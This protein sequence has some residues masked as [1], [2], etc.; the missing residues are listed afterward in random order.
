M[1]TGSSS[2]RFSVNK[3][4]PHCDLAAAF[5]AGPLA[6]C[7]IVWL[8]GDTEFTLLHPR[9]ILRAEHLVPVHARG[10]HQRPEWRRELGRPPVDDHDG[11][12][13]GDPEHR[14]RPTDR[15]QVPVDTPISVS[16]STSMA[17]AATEDAIQL[18]PPVPGTRVVRNRIDTSRFV[19]LPGAT[20]ESGVTYRLSIAATAAT[21]NQQPLV[22]AS[23]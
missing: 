1:D 15:D 18:S 2:G 22:P 13:P 17:A 5:S 7:R 16:F 23:R 14:S 9:A 21:L 12:G 11:A 8:D 10:R 20:L 4:I 3:P 6:P 19:V